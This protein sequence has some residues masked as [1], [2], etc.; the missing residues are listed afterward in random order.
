MPKSGAISNKYLFLE[1]GFI[2][3]IGGIFSLGLKRVTVMAPA[4]FGVVVFYF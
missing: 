1:L 3:L 4:D 2:A